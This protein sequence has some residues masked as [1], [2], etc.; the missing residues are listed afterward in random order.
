MKTFPQVPINTPFFKVDT[1]SSA[2]SQAQNAGNIEHG[3]QRWF[4][5]VQT[6][7][8]VAPQFQSNIP[9]NSAANG[10]PGTIAFDHNFLYIA[11]AQNTW[12]RVA[13]SSF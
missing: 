4:Q 1:N 2:P 11:V 10:A 6:S 8:S 7:L 9:A 3:W 5:T 13:I 12:R